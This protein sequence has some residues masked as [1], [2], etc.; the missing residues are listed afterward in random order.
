MWDDVQRIEQA[1][2]D[3]VEHLVSTFSF[4]LGALHCDEMAKVFGG[5]GLGRNSGN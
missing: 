2:E 5:G 1:A 4:V 3:K